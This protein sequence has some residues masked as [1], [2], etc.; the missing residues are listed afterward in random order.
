M[1]RKPAQ[2]ELAYPT[3]KQ[4]FVLDTRKKT[5]KGKKSGK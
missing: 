5:K 1:T 4:K 3:Q 2:W